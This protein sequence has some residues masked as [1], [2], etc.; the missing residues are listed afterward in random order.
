M[1]REQEGG[2]LV[3]GADLMVSFAEGSARRAE[4]RNNS[5]SIK[6]KKKHSVRS[7]PRLTQ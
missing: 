7:E 4:A 2:D 3:G 6:S 5:S 1:A